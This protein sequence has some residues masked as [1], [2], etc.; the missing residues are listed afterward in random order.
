MAGGDHSPG[1]GMTQLHSPWR[2]NQGAKSVSLNNN[3]PVRDTP[4][5]T[6]AAA[7]ATASPASKAKEPSLESKVKAL[8]AT[9]GHKSFPSV[10]AAVHRGLDNLLAGCSGMSLYNAGDTKREMAFDAA[11][12]AA[13]DVFLRGLKGEARSPGNKAAAKPKPATFLK[14]HSS[15]G[16]AHVATPAAAPAPQAAPAPPSSSGLLGSSGSTT[17]LSMSWP[18]HCSGM[19]P[20]RASSVA[21]AAGPTPW[22]SALLIT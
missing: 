11:C 5:E 1:E 10:L 6:P 22:Y 14:A 2:R 8:A 12:K 16:G 9:L 20:G 4:V 7:A 13:A 18:A 3:S 19:P 21:V 17:S 15:K